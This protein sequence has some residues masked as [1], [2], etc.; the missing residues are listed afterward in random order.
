[1]DRQLYSSLVKNQL[2]KI[3]CEK[4]STYDIQVA[5][6]QLN[7]ILIKNALKAAP[8]KKIRR[9]RKAKLTVYTPAIK[10]V[11]QN[12]K[13]AFREWKDGGRPQETSDTLLMNKK[14]SIKQLR[15]ACHIENAQLDQKQKQ[16]IMDAKSS[17]TALFHKLVKKTKRTVR[18]LCE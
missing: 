4:T 1:M 15:K 8:V 18:C 17:D 3:D 7:D 10:E 13:K 2:P 5:V 11:I 14:S 12:K 6:Q 9:H 16:E